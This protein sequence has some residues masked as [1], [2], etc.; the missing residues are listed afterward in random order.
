MLKP[1]GT[2][3]AGNRQS[4]PGTPQGSA[5]RV[6]LANPSGLD[7]YT[8]D[9]RKYGRASSHRAKRAR[10]PA[11]GMM[12]KIT[13][14]AVAL[15][16]AFAI[17]LTADTFLEIPGIPGSSNSKTHRGWIEIESFQW[18]LTPLRLEPGKGVASACSATFSAAGES[19]VT[20]IP[21][22]GKQ[23]RG[24]VTLEKEHPDTALT[25]YRVVMEDVVISN[26]VVT[27]ASSTGA[28]TENVSLNFE[29]IKVTYTEQQKDGT[30]G[31]ATTVSYDCKSESK[32]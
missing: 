19:L 3:H 32:K 12:R 14:T 8:L 27:A 18:T 13:F 6:E 29:E 17:P 28:P 1:A 26:Y 24:A 7:R 11:G 23:I 15:L 20:L 9:H 22:V 10:A 4:T 21:N 25:Y 31:A 2:V 30:A 5:H 16:F